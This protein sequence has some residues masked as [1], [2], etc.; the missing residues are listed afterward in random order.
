MSWPGCVR[1]GCPCGSPPGGLVCMPPR[2]VVNWHATGLCGPARISPNAP[3][4]W[5]GS[6]NGDQSVPGRRRSGAAR[7]VVPAELVADL[8]TVREKYADFAAHLARY[9]YDFQAVIAALESDPELAAAVAG[10]ADLAFAAAAG[11]L[12]DLVAT[13][14]GIVLDPF[15]LASG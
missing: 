5:P 7:G 6:G 8:E 15:Q 10:V 13:E 1:R 3:T 2:S 11:R 4:G 12:R 9:D 14:C